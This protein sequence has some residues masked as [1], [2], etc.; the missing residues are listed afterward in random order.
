MGW[1]GRELGKVGY[2][3]RNMLSRSKRAPGPTKTPL[4]IS[5]AGNGNIGN[6]S[7]EKMTADQI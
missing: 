4:T 7:V 3:A 6:G 1:I 2:K 5:L